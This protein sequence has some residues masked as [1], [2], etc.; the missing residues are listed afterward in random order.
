MLSLCRLG[1][2]LV[3]F[4]ISFGVA[5]CS[6]GGNSASNNS[7]TAG[8]YVS[9]I[10]TVPSLPQNGTPQ[11]IENQDN[12]SVSLV[13]YVEDDQGNLTLI[14]QQGDGQFNSLW[15]NRFTL[16]KG[17]AG[18]QLLESEPGDVTFADLAVNQLGEVMVVWGQETLVGDPLVGRT[19][20]WARIFSG[21]AW[22]VA[23]KIEAMDLSA[24]QTASIR[25]IGS[26]VLSA[27]S[28]GQF[29]A[30]WSQHDGSQY[31]AWANSYVGGQWQ[32]AAT[33]LDQLGLASVSGL[34]LV[35]DG[36]G[37]VLASW[38]QK[39]QFYQDLWVDRFDGTSW[40][41]ATKLDPYDSGDVAAV[42]LLGAQQGFAVVWRHYVESRRF[43]GML[44]ATYNG[45]WQVHEQVTSVP[46]ASVLGYDAVLESGGQLTVAWVE[47]VGSS[48]TVWANQYSGAWRGANQISL[49]NQESA[50]V[51]GL[52][53]D[54]SGGVAA[55]W[56]QGDGVGD[57]LWSAELA[58]AAAWTAAQQISSTVQSLDTVTE[59]A[60][61][62]NS[63]GELAVVW[64]LEHNGQ[65]N[66]GANRFTGA[67]WGSSALVESFDGNAASPEVVIDESGN[68]T[69]VWR[70]TWG[71]DIRLMTARFLTGAGWQGGATLEAEGKQN[72]LGA[73]LVLEP[74]SQVVVFWRQPESVAGQNAPRYDLW[75]TTI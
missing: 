66:L 38:L 73:S 74:S 19:D 20:L 11:L 48:T 1:G 27:T 44:A 3:A 17:W 26:A 53:F 9:N 65:F 71:S 6:S 34:Q 31:Q 5:G 45:S 14:W 8:G 22:Q 23:N 56:L 75:A 67:G 54:L 32:P 21:G 10:Q 24:V 12:G 70:H 52:Y 16:A 58:P 40:V 68:T 36:S 72:G 29:V 42:R 55:I 41:T 18:E 50:D 2:Y 39:G 51:P 37:A 47:S 59:Y 69:V 46:E 49:N 60:V 25:D 35:A 28:G 4:T 30:V 7:G 33:R 43:W 64:V 15:T 62:R 57:Q 63:R 61:S 13:D